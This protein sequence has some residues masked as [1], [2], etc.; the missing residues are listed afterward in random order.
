M[1]P[2]GYNMIYKYKYKY[3]KQITL[4]YDKDAAYASKV[5][6]GEKKELCTIEME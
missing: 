5:E 3:I 6:L 4:T 1:I 2:K